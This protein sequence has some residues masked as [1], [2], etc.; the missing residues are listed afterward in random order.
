[1]KGLLFGLI[2]FA[3]I[4]G[5]VWLMAVM[6]KSWEYAI[7]LMFFIFLFSIV[8]VLFFEDL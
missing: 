6:L 5:F 7:M 1:M 8:K 2:V 3:V 4:G